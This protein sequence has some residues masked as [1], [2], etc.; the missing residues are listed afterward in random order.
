VDFVLYR[1]PRDLEPDQVEG[2]RDAL[3]DFSASI[4][5]QKLQQVGQLIDRN[6]SLQHPAT[7]FSRLLKNLRPPTNRAS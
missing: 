7:E 2:I 6:D 1:T 3:E 5:I 4:R